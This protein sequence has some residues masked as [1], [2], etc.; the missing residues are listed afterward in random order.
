MQGMELTQPVSWSEEELRTR[1]LAHDGPAWREFHRRYDRLI[2]RSIQKVTQRF[3]AV[4]TSADAEEVFATLLCS[5]NQRDMHKLRSFDPERGHRLG[6]WIAML[7]TH[8]TW[9][10]LRRVARTPGHDMGTETETIYCLAPDPFARLAAKEEWRQVEAT[11]DR[12]SERDRRFVEL[13]F[14]QGRSPE[15]IAETMQISVKTVYSKKHKI[16]SRLVDA[17]GRGFSAAA[18]A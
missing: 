7:A 9:D 2:L 3:S 17:L 14:L 8:A 12:F 13:F 16:R 1:M 6:S 10:Y 18:A 15:Q 4:L 5:L 11:L